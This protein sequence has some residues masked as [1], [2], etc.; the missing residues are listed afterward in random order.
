MARTDEKPK[1]KVRYCLIES[2]TG[3]TFHNFFSEEQ[4]REATIR[5]GGNYHIAQEILDENGIPVKEGE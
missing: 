2:E 4:A 3:L 1:H 5:M